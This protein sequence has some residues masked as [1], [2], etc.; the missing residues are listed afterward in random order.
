MTEEQLGEILDN[1]LGLLL[2]EGSYDI[3]EKEGMFHV[4]IQTE[5]AGRVIGYR[6]EALEALQL[7]TSQLAARK[8]DQFKRV[9]IDVEGWR[10]QKESDLEE[11]AKEWAN[12]AVESGQPLELE[13]MP[14]WQ[15]RAVH[16]ALQDIEGV[17]TESVGEGRDRHL[18]IKPIKKSS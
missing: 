11:Q 14:P 17:E 13:P 8:S 15:R 3:E 18:V 16:V 10:K 5:D 4:L 12:Q 7:I 2:L 6:G 1:V 9:V